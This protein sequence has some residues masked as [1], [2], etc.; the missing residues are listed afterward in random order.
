MSQKKVSVI[1]PY[2]KKKK[3]FFQSFMSAVR[4]TYK[5]IEIIIIYDDVNKIDLDF[6]KKKTKNFKKIKIINNRKNLGAG[7]S[8]NRGIR[9]SNGF[10]IAF[11]DCDDIWHKSKL[12]KQISFMNKHSVDFSYTSFYVINNFR[13][14]KKIRKVTNEISYERLCRGCDIGLSTVVVKKNIKKKLIFSNL[15]T[16]EDFCLWLDLLKKGVKFRSFDI[17]LSYWRELPN[18]LSSDSVQK[19]KDCFRL[20]YYYQN[21]NFLRSIYQVIIVS[22]NKMLKNVK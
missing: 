16:Q 12:E 8:R 19:V 9:I 17:P 7:H 5:N 21:M 22:L 3:Y 4:Q 11:L 20:F 15:K 18:S 1:M 10:Y 2:Y 14:I 13:K 6:L